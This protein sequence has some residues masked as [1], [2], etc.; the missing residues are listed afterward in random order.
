LNLDFLK[1]IKMKSKLLAAAVALCVS[2]GMSVASTVVLHDDFSSYG[3]VTTL[4]ADSS[5]FGANWNVS[6]GT[7][8]YLT[9]S[10]IWGPL[11]V[12]GGNC[13]D[14]DGSSHNAGVF[15]SIAVFAAGRY[16]LDLALFGSGRGASSESVTVTIG[17]WSTTI[18]PIF[19]GDDASGTWTLSTSGGVL[20]FA[21]AGGDNAGAILSS[22]TLSA[23]PIPATGLLL[24]GALGA[25]GALGGLGRARRKRK[26]D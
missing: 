22:V 14:L 4:N 20:S 18:F 16:Q 24:L 26:A 3:S 21:N 7:V 10:G 23:V 17:D 5:F 8:D 11:C 12:G 19:P 15:S 9:Q 1:E 25:L 2:A 6:F 13:I